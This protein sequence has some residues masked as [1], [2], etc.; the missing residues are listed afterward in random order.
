MAS[1][2]LG[3]VAW[4]TGYRSGNS[5]S[6]RRAIST[7]GDPALGVNSASQ[8]LSGG[9]CDSPGGVGPGSRELRN[10]RLQASSHLSYSRRLPRSHRRPAL[11]KP[12]FG[13]YFT[14]MQTYLN[15]RL[16]FLRLLLINGAINPGCQ[17]GWSEA[18]TGERRRGKEP[19]REGTSSGGWGARGSEDLRGG[20]A[21]RL[22]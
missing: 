17:A 10:A 8:L 5:T 16:V 11:P 22:T 14:L 15:H 1:P 6:E 19:S 9:R 4:E 2:H 7:C 3:S 18:Q 21:R 13:P 20:D 12:V